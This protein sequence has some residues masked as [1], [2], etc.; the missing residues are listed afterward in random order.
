MS[1][2]IGMT[3]I[4]EDCACVEDKKSVKRQL[5]IAKERLKKVME[6]VDFINIDWDTRSKVIGGAYSDVYRLKQRLKNDY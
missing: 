3:K 5:K 6:A 4:A 1:K 2:K